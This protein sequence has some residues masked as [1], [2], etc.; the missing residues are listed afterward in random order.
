VHS[1][2]ANGLHKEVDVTSIGDRLIIARLKWP[3]AIS[4]PP[5]NFFAELKLWFIYRVAIGYTIGARLVQITSTVRHV[6]DLASVADA[7]ASNVDLRVRLLR[8]ALQRSTVMSG[9]FMS[10]KQ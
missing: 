8:P 2:R 3:D 9:F 6:L 5:S 7:G 10:L 1:D 4:V